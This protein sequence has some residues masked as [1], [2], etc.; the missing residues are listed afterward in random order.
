MKL[1]SCNKEDCSF[2]GLE[3]ILAN[4]TDSILC[5]GC[6]EFYFKDDFPDYEQAEQ[7]P[8]ATWIGN[9]VNE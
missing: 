5:G 1:F 8:E 4:P 3:I 6:G 9:E 7:L 2:G